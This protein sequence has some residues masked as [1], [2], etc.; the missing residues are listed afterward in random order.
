MA[1]NGEENPFGDFGMESKKSPIRSRDG[2]KGTD[3]E[4]GEGLLC[5]NYWHREVPMKE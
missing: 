4:C 2:G 3:A 1:E 5:W